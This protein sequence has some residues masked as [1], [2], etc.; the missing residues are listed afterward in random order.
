MLLALER[1]DPVVRLKDGP[2]TLRQGGLDLLDRRELDA[3]LALG[4]GLRPHRGRPAGQDGDR[5]QPEVPRDRVVGRLGDEVVDRLVEPL[6]AGV[7]AGRKT[8]IVTCDFGV[9]R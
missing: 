1:G 4:A 2:I 3:G 8:V 6:L 7:Y 9:R 5:Q